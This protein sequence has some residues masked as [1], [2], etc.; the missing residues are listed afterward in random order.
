MTKVFAK[1]AYLKTHKLFEK[2]VIIR[3]ASPFK[4]GIML[5]D[6]YNYKSLNQNIMPSIEELMEAEGESSDGSSGS[7]SKSYKDSDE[8]KEYKKLKAEKRQIRK[9]EKERLLIKLEEL[10]DEPFT[11]KEVQEIH[12]YQQDDPFDDILNMRNSAKLEFLS[13]QDKHDIKQYISDF[14]FDRLNVKAPTVA[15]SSRN[16]DETEIGLF[17]KVN[18]KV[19]QTENKDENVSN[20][21]SAKLYQDDAQ[22]ENNTSMKMDSSYANLIRNK[23]QIDADDTDEEGDNDT[24]RPLN[25][26][27]FASQQNNT[28]N[29]LFKASLGYVPPNKF[30]SSAFSYRAQKSF[31]ETFGSKK[32][33]KKSSTKGSSEFQGK[34]RILNSEMDQI[35]ENELFK[36]DKAGEYKLKSL[37]IFN[38]L[39]STKSYV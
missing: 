17:N 14:K 3:D 37:E 11:L 31:K 9:I 2:L 5:F 26:D 25:T 39:V 23:T 36:Q 4:R 6:D 29:E 24:G 8:E 19:N 32:S 38:N 27:I 18:T 12:Y 21:D 20:A 34:K 35:I 30:K 28:V 22:I 13:L 7:D 16:N 10:E 1:D 15:S 33:L